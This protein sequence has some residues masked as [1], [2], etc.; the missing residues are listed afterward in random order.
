M[1][2]NWFFIPFLF[3]IYV[4]F[5]TPFLQNLPQV[6]VL[7]YLL[8][9]HHFFISNIYFP[10]FLFS[11]IYLLLSS[12]CHSN[13]HPS[14]FFPH[15]FLSF[16]FSVIYYQSYLFFDRP[17]FRRSFKFSHYFIISLLNPS[18]L[19]TIS[20]CFLNNLFFD[21]IFYLKCLFY[22]LHFHPFYSFFFYQLY[23]F[24]SSALPPPCSSQLRV[25]SREGVGVI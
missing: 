10:Q 9:C 11:S 18:F 25:F 1:K 14:L 23:S 2:I 7:V 3:P 13:F 17:F 20:S 6:G 19:W 22:S 16:V 24:W 4:L 21:C 12:F 8:F 5:L 15:P